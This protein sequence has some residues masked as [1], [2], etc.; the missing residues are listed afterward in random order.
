[1]KTRDPI[2]RNEPD[3]GK[4]VERVALPLATPTLTRIRAL[5]KQDNRTV[6]GEIRYLLATI[7]IPIEEQRLGLTRRR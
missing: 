7:A 1:M 6:L 2:D 5:A 3:Y 4:M